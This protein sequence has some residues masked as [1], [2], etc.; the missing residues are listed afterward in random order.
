MKLNT[1]TALVKEILEDDPQARN[2]D[3]YLYCQVCDRIGKENGID[4][5]QM[6]IT[7]VLLHLKEFGLPSIETVGRCRRKIVERYPELAGE[8]KVE[9]MRSI[10]EEKFRNYARQNLIEK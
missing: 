1:I 2:S 10:N 6:P 9:A 4:I 5:D 7:R 8:D 3:S